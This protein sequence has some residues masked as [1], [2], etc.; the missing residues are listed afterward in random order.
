MASVF[1]FFAD[2]VSS[3][4]TGLLSVGS[5]SGVPLLPILFGGLLV[6]LLLAAI[7]INAGGDRD[8]D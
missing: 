5:A 1:E 8:A 3:I 7:K 2:G 4:V 6:R